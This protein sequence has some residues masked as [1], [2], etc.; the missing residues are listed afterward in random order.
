MAKTLTELLN[1]ASE[2]RDADQDGENTADRVGSLLVDVIEYINETGRVVNDLT[3]GGKDV[4]LS[5]EMGKELGER[6]DELELGGGGG[7]TISYNENTKTTTFVYGGNVQELSTSPT[8]SVQNATVGKTATITLAT[9]LRLQYSTDGGTTWIDY[10]QPIAFTTAGTT[11]LLARAKESGKAW[12]EPATA[13]IVVEGTSQPTISKLTETD[14]NVTFK[15]TLANATV[16]ISTD[17]TTW[18]SGNGSATLTVAKTTAVQ[19]VTIHAKA[20]ADGMLESSAM[21]QAFEVAA[22]FQWEANALGGTSNVALT[23]N[24]FLISGLCDADGTNPTSAIADADFS[25]EAING[26]YRWKVLFPTASGSEIT[27]LQGAKTNGSSDHLYNLWGR[28]FGGS[29]DNRI[30]SIDHMPDS[31]TTIAKLCLSCLRSVG[32]ITIGKNV[33]SVF[34]S[35]GNSFVKESTPSSFDV[36]SGNATFSVRDGILYNGNVLILYPNGKSGTVLQIEEGTTSIG[37]YAFDG[38]TTIQKLI[39]PS[40]I[41]S[42]ASSASMTGMKAV[43]EII[44]NG[45][46]AVIPL[47]TCYSCTA[48]TKVTLPASVATIQGT[49]FGKAPLEEIHMLGGTPPNLLDTSTSTFAT[50]PKVYVPDAT[51][52]AAYQANTKWVTVAGSTDNILVEPS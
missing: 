15:A 4:A 17:G 33:N 35:A 8:I 23:K 7:V 18:T 6:V 48:L 34:T 36:E 24:D 31:I 44:F 28:L 20:K 16:Y 10:T 11:V 29:G 49:V 38:N 52:Q 1:L 39:L 25:C 13:T 21:T 40:T 41:T 45:T 19:N 14:N 51:A 5:A 22:K 46:F 30:T 50:H 26:G 3:T 27:T 2:I 47:S 43:R 32:N 9:A 12:S 37:T 42:L